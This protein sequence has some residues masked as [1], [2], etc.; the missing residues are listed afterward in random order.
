MAIKVGVSLTALQ[1][2]RTAN[3][4][5]DLI[6]ALA[7]HLGSAPVA[8]SATAYGRV[9]VVA[10]APVAPPPKAEVGTEYSVHAASAKAEVGTESSVDAAPTKVEP[11]VKAP[12]VAPPPVVPP[13]AAVAKP[14]VVAKP[15]AVDAP[16]PAPVRTVAPAAAPVRAAAPALAPARTTAPPPAAAPPAPAPVRAVAPALAPVRTTA[17]APA[18]VRTTAPAAAA[19]PEPVELSL[20]ERYHAF[21]R[22]LP[23]RSQEFLKLVEERGTVTISEVMR[24]LGLHLPKAMGGITGSIG[25]WA[26]VK[27]VPLPY[28][29]LEKDGERAWRWTGIEGVTRGAHVPPPKPRSAPAIVAAPAPALAAPV[30]DV[31]KPKVSK[32]PKVQ[33]PPPAPPAPPAARVVSTSREDR[34]IEA[35]PENSRQFMARLRAEHVIPVVDAL[36]M[37]NLN[38]PKALGGVLEP[39]RRIAREHGIEIPF[40]VG[41]DAGGNRQYYW[42]GHAP[43]T[44]SIGAAPAEAPKAPP[45]GVLRRKKG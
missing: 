31:A 20:G 5:R 14:V 8:E 26:P 11:A 34:F 41:T 16:A 29:Q 24:A 32:A 17:P 25:R 15:A 19:P 9:A 27:K 22:N 12:P 6:T 7:E 2:V 10:T 13:P 1:D 30:V 21:V 3:A 23:P 36:R 45:P 35:L 38:R 43:T 42:P 40:E 28:E 39:I 44:P 4:V 33:P 37:F 18:P